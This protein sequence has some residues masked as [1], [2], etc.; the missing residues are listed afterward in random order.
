MTK[1]SLEK[2][3][4]KSSTELESVPFYPYQTSSQDLD[5]EVM[6]QTHPIHYPCCECLTI[7]L[8]KF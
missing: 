1:E 5:F 6:Y 4:H 3:T 7:V 2:V 8:F